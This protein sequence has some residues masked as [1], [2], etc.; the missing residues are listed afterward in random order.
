MNGPFSII[1]G[2]CSYAFISNLLCLCR[3]GVGVRSIIITNYDT[4]CRYWNIVI[5]WGH[6]LHPSFFA[7]VLSLFHGSTWSN[8]YVRCTGFISQYLFQSSRIIENLCHKI[9]CSNFCL[10]STLLNARKHFQPFHSF[11]WVYFFQNTTCCQ[12]NIFFQN[13]T[14]SR[15]FFKVVSQK[16]WRPVIHSFKRAGFFLKIS[17]SYQFFSVVW[18]F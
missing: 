6:Q 17:S 10:K 13:T 8:P 16:E 4:S 12:Y 18:F 11:R 15:Q 14:C 9:S 7:M 1:K 2:S 3:T 5:I